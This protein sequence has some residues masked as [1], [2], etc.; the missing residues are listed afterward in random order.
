MN[1]TVLERLNVDS[2][3]SSRRLSMGSWE[4]MITDT[5]AERSPTPLV[6]W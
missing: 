3:A 6:S 4:I 2:D 1:L 5:G